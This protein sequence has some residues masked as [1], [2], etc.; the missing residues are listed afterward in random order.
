MA[1]TRILRENGYERRKA[2]ESDLKEAQRQLSSLIGLQ[3]QRENVHARDRH[4]YRNEIETLRRKI[5]DD[6][7][8]EVQMAEQILQSE[9][10]IAALVASRDELVRPTFYSVFDAHRFKRKVSL[11]ETVKS[12]KISSVQCK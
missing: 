12:S 1:E 8:N 11:A 10:R 2:L 9:R 7:E 5:Q 3:T 4:Q 6:T